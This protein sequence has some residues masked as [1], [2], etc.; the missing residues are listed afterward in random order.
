MFKWKNDAVKNT[1]EK[2]SRAIRTRIKILAFLAA[3]PL[4]S[5]FFRAYELQIV[6]GAA[7]LKE[8][9][10]QT[11]AKVVIEP[12]R[13]DIFDRNGAPIV[14]TIKTKSLFIRPRE[15]VVAKEELEAKLIAIFPQ[16]EPLI[17]KQFQKKGSFIWIL[18]NL[19]LEDDKKLESS[20]ILKTADGLPMPGIGTLPENTRSYPYGELAAPIIGFVNWDGEGLMGIEK[21]YDELLKGRKVILKGSCDARRRVGLNMLTVDP[22]LN[23]G[24]SLIL[25]IDK[26][27][28]YIAEKAIK[29]AVEKAEARLGIAIISDP[30]SGELLAI[31]EYPSFDISKYYLYNDSDLYSAAV[32]EVFEPGSTLKTV[33]I[34]GALDKNA[35]KAG[36]VFNVGNGSLKIG[37]NTIHDSH[38]SGGD[39]SFTVEEI[40]VKSS[41]V[42]TALMA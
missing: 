7:L 38:G 13:G 25:T 2:K 37:P 11:I 3:I 12:A 18:K 24:T 10:D 17:R 19:T 31:A 8:S 20:G 27:Y 30:Q 4:L 32:E 34:A 23:K 26:D 35:V 21:S 16:Y 6:K 36:D 41:N 40:L 28:Q 42:G 33:T 14:S 5:L 9:K 22:T 29:D 1:E 39:A 15:L